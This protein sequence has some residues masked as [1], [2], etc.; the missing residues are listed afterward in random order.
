M[1][2]SAF[3]L[4]PVYISRISYHSPEIADI[5]SNIDFNLSD[6]YLLGLCM[7]EAASLI[8]IDNKVTRNV[9]D[10]ILKEVENRYSA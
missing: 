4:A 8:S 5:Q 1:D 9:L 10:E 7:A 3:N 6:V 2:P